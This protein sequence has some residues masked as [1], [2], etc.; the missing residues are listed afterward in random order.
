MFFHHPQG[1]TAMDKSQVGTGISKSGMSERFEGLLL[2]GGTLV[3]LLRLAAPGV[4][5]RTI[6]RPIVRRDHGSDRISAD[7]ACGRRYRYSFWQNSRSKHCQF[8]TTVFHYTFWLC[9]FELNGC[10][11]KESA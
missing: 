9:D 4:W 6:S 1:G 5:A 10:V 7:L 11:I 2:S 3:L 8:S